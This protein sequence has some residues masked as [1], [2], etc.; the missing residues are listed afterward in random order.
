LRCCGFIWLVPG[1][2]LLHFAAA[3]RNRRLRLNLPVTDA[4]PPRS[5]SHSHPRTAAWRTAKGHL[6]CRSKQPIN[7][8]TN[9]PANQ[10]A[11]Q[12]INQSTNQPINQSTNQ[13]INQST[14]QPAN[15]P[16]NQP[17]NQSTSQPATSQPASQQKDYHRH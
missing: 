16:A 9:Q 7:Q 10:P 12:P 6:N 3:L 14:N 15:Q 4:Q 2:C 17:I 1:W 11:N 8:S 5:G 13:P